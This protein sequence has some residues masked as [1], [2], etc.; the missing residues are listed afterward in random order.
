MKITQDEVVFESDEV[1]ENYG[2]EDPRVAYRAK[3]KTYYMLYSAVEQF[4]NPDKVVSKLALATTQTPQIKGSWVRMG[5]VFPNISWS[6]SG[7][8]ILRDEDGGPHYLIWGDNYLTMAVSE[9][10]STFTNLPG[11]F[12]STRPDH[13]D[14]ALVES[15]PPP[16]RLDDGNYFFIYNSARAGFPSPRPGYE[17]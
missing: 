17:L 16:L 10:L 11:P 8:L 15:G 5:D 3:D 7:A 13:F 12:L 2:V 14:S 4:T 1:W 6:K 9:D